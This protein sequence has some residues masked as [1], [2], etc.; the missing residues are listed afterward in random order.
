MEIE[1][2][3]AG[4]APSFCARGEAAEPVTGEGSR[5]VDPPVRPDGCCAQCGG[6]RTV[7]AQARKYAGYQ[8]DLDPYCSARCCRRWHGCP[9][10]NEREEER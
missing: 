6:P 5:T 1:P 9:L 4:R 2:R 10:K 8:V 3:T 7:T